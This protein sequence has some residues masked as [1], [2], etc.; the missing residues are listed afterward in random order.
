VAGARARVEAGAIVSA[1]MA[2][3]GSDEDDKRDA[4]AAEADGLRDDGKSVVSIR[5][6][7]GGKIIEHEASPEPSSKD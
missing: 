1:R 6:G 3:S 7:D 4:E 2:V 5:W